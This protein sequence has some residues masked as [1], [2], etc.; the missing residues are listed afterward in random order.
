MK[1]TNIKRFKLTILLI[2][3]TLVLFGQTV[4]KLTPSETKEGWIL[5]FDGTTTTHWTSAD[6]S[7]FPKEGWEIENSVLT[8]KPS[9]GGHGG[10]DIITVDEYSDFEFSVDF[11]TTPNANSGIKYFYTNYEKGG[12]LGLEYQILDDAEPN[13]GNLVNHV[14]GSLYDMFAPSQAKKLNSVGEWNTARIVSKG[15]HLEQ[16]L[17][18]VKVVEFERGSITYMKALTASKYKDAQPTF[19]LV[20]KGHILLQEHGTE[21]SFR[22]IKVRKL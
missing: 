17:N 4:N 13:E 21:V 3:C 8:V 7:A 18:N 15:K 6:G 11:K 10:G 16:W 20:A 19:G 9:P 22:N 1:I 2:S 12:R 14:C 5:L